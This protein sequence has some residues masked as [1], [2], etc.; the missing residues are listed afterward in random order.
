MAALDYDDDRSPFTS[1]GDLED[2]SNLD[3]ILME[4]FDDDEKEPE[5][6]ALDE[7]P[8]LEDEP[9]L[10]ELDEEEVDDED[11]AEEEFN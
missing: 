9:V 4:E 11:G 3:E 2:E 8:I 5:E 6:G 1:A 10:E 7:I